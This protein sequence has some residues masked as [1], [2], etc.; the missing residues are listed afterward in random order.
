MNVEDDM[1]YAMTKKFYYNENNDI[2]D[3]HFA[4]NGDHITTT[5]VS[6]YYGLE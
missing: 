6:S 4:Y 5:L 2:I 3:A 1:Q